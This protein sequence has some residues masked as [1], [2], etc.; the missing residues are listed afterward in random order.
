[1][2]EPAVLA[3][4]VPEIARPFHTFDLHL[5]LLESG[6]VTTAVAATD[7]LTCTAQV[8]DSGG[9]TVVHSHRGEDQVFLV[10]GGEATF[11]TDAEAQ[12]VACV[13]GPLQGVLIPRHTVYWYQKTSADNLVLVRFGAKAL[14]E[15]QELDRL[16]PPLRA[17]VPVVVSEG[18]AFS[19]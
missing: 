16:S 9:E 1:M 18:R 7:V 4:T 12:N 11:Y 5:P 3:E 19:R 14:G 17:P 13:L 15:D 10:L 8:A 6:K 2:P